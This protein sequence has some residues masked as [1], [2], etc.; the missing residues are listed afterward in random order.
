MPTL[1]H[2][3][4]R[5]GPSLAS[6]GLHCGGR[7]TRARDQNASLADI[8][9]IRDGEKLKFPLNASEV[10]VTLIRYAVLCQ[11]LFQ[12]T[13]NKHPAFRGG[14]MGRRHKVQEL[15]TIHHFAAARGI[16][17]SQC[18]LSVYPIM[19]SI[20]KR[21]WMT[22]TRTRMPIFCHLRNTGT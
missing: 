6:H 4:C 20:S 8:R 11:T 14:I 12:G 13:G 5:V 9:T 17:T 22:L 2:V 15:G 16:L 21:I 10:C 3:L 18:I 7:R 19:H 1:P